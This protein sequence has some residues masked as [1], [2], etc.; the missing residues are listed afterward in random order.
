[1]ERFAPPPRPW[2]HQP[3]VKEEKVMAN[4]SN[5]NP[6]PFQEIAGPFSLIPG[7]TLSVE[8]ALGTLLHI[9]QRGVSVE[10]RLERPEGR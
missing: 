3:P 4:A 2:P 10:V 7:R 9:T 1:M 5:L 6:L 8:A